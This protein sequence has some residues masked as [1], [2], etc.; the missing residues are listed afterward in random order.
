MIR[1]IAPR[2]AAGPA[3]MAVAAAALTATTA[4]AAHAVGENSQCT[5]NWP[6]F[7]ATAGKNAWNFR[8]GPSPG[9]RSLGYLYRGDKLTVM[10]SRGSWD[11]ARIISSK[12]G[13]RKGT[14]GW[15]RS[16]GLINLAG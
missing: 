2:A 10:C 6:D 12:S 3:A 1:R 8:S 5:H 7:T 4:P 11:C 15:V 9:Y 13:I 14:K 16:D